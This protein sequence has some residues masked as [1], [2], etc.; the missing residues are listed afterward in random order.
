M[1]L[2]IGK[3]IYSILSGDTTVAFFVNKKINPIFT[4]DNVITPFIVFERKNINTTYSNNGVA[5]DEDRIL[6]NIVSENYPEC[7]DIAEAVRN[8]LEL[9]TGS[10]NGV[11]IFSSTLENAS[12]NYGVDGYITLLEFTIMCKSE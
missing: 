3:A 10:F 4:P 7:I 6:V 8:A 12:E 9:K 2:I 5:Y 1:S 11:T